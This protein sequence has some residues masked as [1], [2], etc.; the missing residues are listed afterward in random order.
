MADIT[1]LDHRKP[2]LAR[3]F[4]A[5]VSSP[6]IQSV[7]FSAL[8]QTL[9]LSALITAKDFRMVSGNPT[10]TSYEQLE[11]DSHIYDQVSYACIGGGDSGQTNSFPTTK[12]D[13]MR[14]QV[15]FPQCWNGVVSFLLLARSLRHNH[16]LTLR[17][18]APLYQ[19]SDSP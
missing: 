14:P 3:N 19:D 1:S 7:V 11:K 4:T 18:R 13:K 12:C 9:S 8:A 17:K 15:R 10:A 6:C 2:F 16:L 5:S